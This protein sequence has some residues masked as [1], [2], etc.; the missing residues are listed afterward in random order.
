[1]QRNPDS[2]NAGAQ[3]NSQ[4]IQFSK[5]LYQL[6]S[7]ITHKGRS[8]DSG[9]YMSWVRQEDESKWWKFDDDKVSEMFTEDVMKLVGGGDRE[10]AYL[11]LYRVKL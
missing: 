6:H 1:M 4:S 8:A 10:M 11:L 5:G 2:L 3:V 7:I 9:H